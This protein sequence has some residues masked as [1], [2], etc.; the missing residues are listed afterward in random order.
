M[1]GFA[2]VI[3]VLAPGMPCQLR[4]TS[5]KLR[6]CSSCSFPSLVTFFFFFLTHSSVDSLGTDLLPQLTG[7]FL[8]VRFPGTI[9]STGL[10]HSDIAKILVLRRLHALR[11]P[12]SLRGHSVLGTLH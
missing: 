10:Q 7:G 9:Q 2:G 5:R 8:V 4:L 1:G 11:R 3:H 12:S 6:S